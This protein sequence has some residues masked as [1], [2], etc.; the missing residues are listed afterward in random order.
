MAKELR[1]ISN[2]EED[3]RKVAQKIARLFHSGDIIVLDGDLGAGKTYFV[4]GFTDGL[5][6]KD[7]VN[8]PT[9]SIANF[10]RT[11]VSDILHIDL[12]RISNMN[13]FNDLGLSDYFDQSIALVEWGKKFAEFFEEYFL[14]S[15]EIN[16]DNTR[17]L[18]FTNQGNKYN[19]TMEKLKTILK[20]DELC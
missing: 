1:I 5:H 9:F 11:D 12:Y 18:T 19:S 6:T 20:G 16:G 7:L 13:E 4:K 17:T 3:T 8:S 14:I 15:F 2:S 10:Y